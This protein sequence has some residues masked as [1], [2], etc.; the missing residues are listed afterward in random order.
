M[1][2]AWRQEIPPEIREKLEERERDPNDAYQSGMNEMEQARTNPGMI[3][4]ILDWY[5][6]GLSL[7]TDPPQRKEEPDYRVFNKEPKG[8]SGA[9][10]KYTGT[11][12]DPI[13]NLNEKE[14]RQASRGKGLNANK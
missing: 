8:I 6:K 7:L 2:D 12:K 5:K 13:Y 3:E 1:G 4:Q 9:A 11:A 14:Y 10:S